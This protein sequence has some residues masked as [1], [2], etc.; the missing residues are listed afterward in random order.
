MLGIGLLLIGGCRDKASTGYLCNLTGSTI[1]YVM[2]PLDT[3]IYAQQISGNRVRVL[4]YNVSNQRAV[5]SV[6]PDVCIW[7]ANGINGLDENDLFIDYIE[8]RT[9]NNRTVYATR[10]EIF[11]QF[12]E[13]ENEVYEIQIT[14]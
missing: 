2:V 10:P 11:S 1:E 13:V 7:I 14:E 5:L 6:D 9:P 12:R 3:A 8:V 4:E